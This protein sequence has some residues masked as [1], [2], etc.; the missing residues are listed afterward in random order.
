MVRPGKAEFRIVGGDFTAN[1]IS[2]VSAGGSGTVVHLK[3]ARFNLSQCRFSGGK[4]SADGKNPGHGVQLTGKASGEIRECIF[5][6]NEGHGLLVKDDVRV[7]VAK[8]GV[9][10][11]QQSGMMFTE[12]SKADVI[13]N[14]VHGNHNG[15]TASASTR[16]IAT[17]NICSENVRMGISV[18][19]TAEVFLDLNKCHGNLVGVRIANT[20]A[21]TIVGQGNNFSLNEQQNLRDLRAKPWAFAITVLALLILFAAVVLNLLKQNPPAAVK[22]QAAQSALAPPASGTAPK[23]F[24]RT[25]GPGKRASETQP[26]RLVET[27]GPSFTTPDREPVRSVVTPRVS[28][29][30]VIQRTTASGS[31]KVSLTAR[32]RSDRK[33]DEATRLCGEAKFRVAVAAYELAIQYDGTNP[34]PRM[35]LARL[36]A[37]C[38]DSSIRDGKR[39]VA[40]ALEGTSL[41]QDPPWSYLAIIAATYAE[42]GDFD[43]AIRW[44]LLAKSKAAGADGG[45][46]D[47]NL[48]RFRNRQPCRWNTEP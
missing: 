32:E 3:D 4:H 37:S 27:S 33:N 16:I 45:A 43:E 22:E 24:H 11:N 13:E 31:S 25:A 15:I 40:L 7:L 9:Q 23:Q 2:F 36:M 38:H 1:G 8:C 44:G 6:V 29:P 20:A 12:R 47:T 21:R 42:A 41:I 46:M 30:A 34:R 26:S 19:D 5:D 35:N 28:S 17:N 48:A 39:A 18:E 10:K 14:F